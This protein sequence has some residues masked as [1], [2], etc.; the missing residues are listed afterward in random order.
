MA[1]YDS[2]W[3][4]RLP[5]TVDRT[6]TTGTQD[7][8]IAIPLMLQHFWDNVDTNGED[9]RITDNDGITGLTFDLASFNKTTQVGS[10]EIQSFAGTDSEHAVCWL[11]YGA[12]GKSIGTTTFTPSTP[13]TGY[14]TPEAP[15]RVLVL[16]AERPGATNPREVV[17]KQVSEAL[18]FYIPVD[19]EFSLR[20][21]GKYEGQG[22][23]EEL[24]SYKFEVTAAG[25]AQASMIDETACRLVQAANGQVY[26]RVL[27]MAG[28]TA[29][30][31]Q[32]EL[33]L[34]STENRSVLRTF[35]IRV[36]DTVET[37]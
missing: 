26:A 8:L 11:Y 6:S 31:Y 24:K 5:M 30:N 16:G 1:W 22:S 32:G 15:S 12:T 9:I 17:H 27:V 29:T 3:S 35:E 7:A 19:V 20:A 37:S 10:I 25:S 13:D 34:T 33:T 14:L 2:D 18:L 4:F 36:A 21:R 28:T 23:F